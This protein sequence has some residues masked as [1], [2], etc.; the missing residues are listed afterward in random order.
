MAMRVGGRRLREGRS[1]SV[2]S[3]PARLHARLQMKNTHVRFVVEPRGACVPSDSCALR[4][5]SVRLFGA[6]ARK[7]GWP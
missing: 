3:R 1:C 6:V 2:R 5:L 4:I 7:G